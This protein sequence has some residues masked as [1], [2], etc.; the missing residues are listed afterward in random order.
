MRTLL[1][2]LVL[3][4]APA[5]AAGQE[6][7][8]K[9]E[10]AAL[11]GA[12]KVVSLEINGESEEVS[13]KPPVWIIR[14]D[15]VLY[16]GEELATLT[17]DPAT[18]PRSV[19]LSFAKPKRVVEGIYALDGDKLKLCVNRQS[20]G[21]KERPNEFATKDKPEWRLLVFER[22]A[23]EK[24]APE[25][26]SGFV[27]V[28]IAADAEKKQIV[29]GAVLDGSPAKKAG[30]MKDDVIVSVGG[31]PASEL[32]AV[33]M[34]CRQATPA[35]ELALRIRRGDKEQDV[36]VKVAVLPFLLLD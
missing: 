31:Q 5:F 22:V 28:Q 25:N 7:G 30:L 19:D 24:A 21:A 9:K 11:R 4:S 13:G 23:E 27:G 33:V 2:G 29:V 6:G 32:R 3:V 12:W 16:G 26:L 17:V 8:A 34:A 18:S 10:L 35:S 15:K 14:D 36:T 20:E 1:A